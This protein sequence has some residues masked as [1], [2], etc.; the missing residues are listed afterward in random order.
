MNLSDVEI[1]IE[2]LKKKILYYDNLYYN[3]GISEISDYEYDMLLKRLEK[4]EISYPQFKSMNSPTSV[5][6]AR[7]VY[8]KFE[9]V[10]HEV[11]M[12]SLQN[13]YS[14]E[15]LFRFHGKILKNLQNV[16]YVVEP[17]VDGLSV[18][19]EYSCGEFFRG[20]T[21]GDGYVGENITENLKYI[22]SVPKKINT[23]LKFLE[24]RA[25]VYMSPN[26]FRLFNLRKQLSNLKKAYFLLVD[27]K[28]SNSKKKLNS[29]FSLLKKKPLQ[30]PRNAASGILKQ[31]NV[32]VIKRAD[33]NLVVFNLQR[34]DGAKFI[35]HVD[36]IEFLHKIGFDTIPES[37]IFS[38]ME[39]CIDKIKEINENRLNFEFEIDGAVVKINSFNDRLK[40]GSTSKFPHWA[41]AYKY[42]P[43]QK[44]TVLLEI[45]IH[46]GRT[47]VL[48][49]VAVFEPVFLSQTVVEKASLHNKNYIK[50]LDIREGDEIIVR[51]AGEII[52][53]VVKSVKHK[54]GSKLFK[55]PEYCPVCGSKVFQAENEVAVKCINSN[56]FATLILN[57]VH[58]ASKS[59]MNM[60]GLGKAIV[61]E[62]VKK[63]LVINVSDL[64]MLKLEDFLILD[65]FNKKSAENA[66]NSIKKAKN[67]PLW[68]LLV[69][70][71][72]SGVGESVAKIL[73]KNY[74]DIF[75]LAN[76]NFDELVQID[77]LGPIISLN[78][79]KYFSLDETKKL[80][81][82]FRELGLN[83]NANYEFNKNKKLKNLVFSVSGKL[84]KF[85]RSEFKNLVEINSGEFSSSVTKRVDFLVVGSNVGSKFE[86]AKKLNL[87]ILNEDQFLNLIL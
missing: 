49:P 58:F 55:M 25:E 82:K 26:Q 30:N 47:G 81:L 6:G 17:K 78:I 8:D 84:N 37:R 16:F 61:A 53:E 45:K 54:P 67:N 71:G 7:V 39:D 10:V 77:G 60:K 59:A 56:C 23:N 85:T 34:V 80:L 63:K 72:I 22:S 19:L 12:E 83:L 46:V 20:S 5:V 66:L 18:S 4:L 14:Y 24:V 64:F 70:L 28:K 21:R 13:A 44:K 29:F 52:P 15:D 69:G 68:R 35:A 40:M 74:S 75:K 36:A 51:K 43:D 38:T 41:I 79:F 50:K 86:K 57:I 73:C 9:K 11:K 27:Y 48:T 3:E 32:N 65:R 31:K 42:E 76:A 33:L 2:N 1:E 87:K 62:L